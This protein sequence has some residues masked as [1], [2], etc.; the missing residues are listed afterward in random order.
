[1][2]IGRENATVHVTSE[3]AYLFQS[4]LISTSSADFVATK[5]NSSV[6]F[7]HNTASVTS[8]LR[9]NTLRRMR[10]NRQIIP[11]SSFQGVPKMVN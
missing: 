7:E 5:T 4:E 3:M 1:M 6:N 9:E 11:H 8:I 10:Q 2:A